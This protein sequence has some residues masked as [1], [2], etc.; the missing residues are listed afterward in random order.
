[1][2]DS[3]RT[4]TLCGQTAVLSTSVLGTEAS[5]TTTVVMRIVWPLLGQQAFGMMS[6]ANKS[7]ITC[8]AEHHLCG[9][10]PRRL[11]L[12]HRLP[13]QAC[14]QKRR[15]IML[16]K[17]MASAADANMILDCVARHPK[18]AIP[19]AHPCF[20]HSMQSISVI[21]SRNGSPAAGVTSR[22]HQSSNMTT[23]DIG[24]LS[25]WVHATCRFHG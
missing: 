22:A 6:P 9:H 19:R 5:P 20:S 25:S 8:A 7:F 16:Q 11:Y 23:N 21:R 13:Y 3:A 12:S 10:H 4:T 2:T 1:M 15:G 24:M 17:S 14:R 18:R